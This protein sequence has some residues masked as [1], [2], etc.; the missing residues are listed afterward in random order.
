MEGYNKSVC[1]ILAFV[2]IS[3]IFK[4]TDITDV[5]ENHDLSPPSNEISLI[6][7]PTLF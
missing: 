4:P 6:E 7:T 3:H 1:Q 2:N 5:V